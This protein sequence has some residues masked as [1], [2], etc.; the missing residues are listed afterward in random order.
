MKWQSRQNVSEVVRRG[1]ETHL[2]L[3]RL[4]WWSGRGAYSYCFEYQDVGAADRDSATGDPLR[5][6]QT[7]LPSSCR[8]IQ[9]KP[10]PPCLAL[11]CLA[12]PFFLTCIDIPAVAPCVVPTCT[13]AI[14]SRSYPP[15]PL[16]RATIPYQHIAQH[17]YHQDDCPY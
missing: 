6:L 13:C 2:R 10:C 15:A 16:T 17:P 11:P 5:Y 8:N 7:H 4:L 3:K 9:T 12:L 14:D 1:K